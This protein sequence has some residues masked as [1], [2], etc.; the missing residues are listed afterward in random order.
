MSRKA[1]IVFLDLRYRYTF[2][3]NSNTCRELPPLAQR[4]ML[5]TLYRAT[6]VKAKTVGNKANRSK[7]REL[8]ARMAPSVRILICFVNS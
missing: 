2:L 7:R 1:Q 5:G 6:M 4:S 3:I 8:E